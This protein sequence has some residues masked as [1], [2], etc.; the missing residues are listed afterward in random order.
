MDTGEN[1]RPG[2]FNKLFAMN[3]PHILEKIFF[4][5]DY[6]AF[7]TCAEVSNTWKELL[8]SESYKK[9]S[10][11]MLKRKTEE[12]LWQFWQ[13]ISGNIYI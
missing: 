7:K 2:P 6:D 9:A 1:M 8:S 4:S 13:Y 5:L 10:E 11:E 3:V 12:Q